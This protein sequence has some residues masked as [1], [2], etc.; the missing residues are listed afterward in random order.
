M[1]NYDKWRKRIMESKNMNK[2]ERERILMI[3]KELHGG[4]LLFNHKVLSVE[5]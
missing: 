3:V 2:G 5:K 1:D 4:F